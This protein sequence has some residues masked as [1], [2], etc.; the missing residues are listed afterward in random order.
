MI[1]V[2]AGGGT[3]LC[4]RECAHVRGRQKRAAQDAR[5]S[6]KKGRPAWSAAA[7]KMGPTSCKSRGPGTGSG[8]IGIHLMAYFSSLQMGDSPKR[9]LRRA[10]LRGGISPHAAP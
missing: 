8:N 1:V 4:R 5:R 7:Q 6:E 2:G 9:S 10:Y 3:G